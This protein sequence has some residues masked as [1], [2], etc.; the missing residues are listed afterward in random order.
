MTRKANFGRKRC[1]IYHNI[2]FPTADDPTA[3]RNVMGTLFL[4]P[5][6]GAYNFAKNN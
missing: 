6:H 4:A 5:R 1:C 2:R 3:R